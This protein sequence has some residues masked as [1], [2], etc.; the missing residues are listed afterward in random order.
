MACEFRH[1]V[2]RRE[3]LE[4]TS[5]TAVVAACG[6]RA[7]A[8]VKQWPALTGEIGITTGSFVRHLSEAHE[9]PARQQALSARKRAGKRER[10][11]S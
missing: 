1:A 5:A 3:F 11:A 7:A 10:P 4:I 8:E 6:N 2:R 9:R